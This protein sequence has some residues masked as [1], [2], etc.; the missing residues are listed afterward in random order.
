MYDSSAVTND[1][2]S[3]TPTTLS[4]TPSKII[5]LKSFLVIRTIPPFLAGMLTVVWFWVYQS[6]VFEHR[7]IANDPRY[8]KPIVR[9]AW[10][11]TACH[12]LKGAIRRC[13]PR[14]SAIQRRSPLGIL[15]SPSIFWHK[16]LI[17]SFLLGDHYS[18][19][20][21]LGSP[22]NHHNRNQG[23][24][25]LGCPKVF[26]KAASPS[27][28]RTPLASVTPLPPKL[29]RMLGEREGAQL[30]DVGIREEAIPCKCG[31]GVCTRTKY[32][33]QSYDDSRTPTLGLVSTVP[34]GSTARIYS[35]YRKLDLALSSCS[36][37][38]KITVPWTLLFLR[39]MGLTN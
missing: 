15:P 39:S 37:I 25:C 27:T 11:L 26:Q 18:L 7:E 36:Q 35:T 33:S 28:S 29:R 30:E 20:Y 6:N 19:F 8:W 38:N 17:I 13:Q 23:F 24:F 32:I 31:V 9:S 16:I 5:L 3:S 10:C 4:L 2:I 12:K 34:S 22:N 1:T 21:S 14:P